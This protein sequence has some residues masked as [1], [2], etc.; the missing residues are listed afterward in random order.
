MPTKLIDELPASKKCHDVESDV[1]RELMAT[2]GIKVSSLV[3]RRLPNGVCLQGVLRFDDGEFDIC[4]SVRRIPG[5]TR[6]LNHMVV[7]REDQT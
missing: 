2:D 7:C 1:R 4:E 3:V 5:I 6:I